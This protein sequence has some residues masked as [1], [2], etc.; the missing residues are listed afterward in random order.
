MLY[1]QGKY[2]VHTGEVPLGMGRGDLTHRSTDRRPKL[3]EACP[4]GVVQVEDR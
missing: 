1:R 2:G 3:Q 4:I